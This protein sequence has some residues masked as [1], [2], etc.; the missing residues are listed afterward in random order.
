MIDPAAA[1]RLSSGRDGFV[2]VAVLWI[3]AALATLVSIYGLYVIN[4]AAAVSA[5]SDSIVADPLVTAGVEL[6]AYQLLGAQTNTRP[7]TGEFTT[8]VGAARLVIAFQTE[9]ARIDIN[10]A[11]KELLRGLFVS[12]GA[13][14]FDA[15]G[16]ANRIIAW[17]TNVAARNDGVI[18][19]DS[20]DSL[21][22]SG[23]LSYTPRHAPFV[24][25]S[26]LWLVY[27]IPRAF[28]ERILPYVTVYSGQAQV[29][30]KDAAPQVVAALPGMSPD[31]LQSTLAARQPGALD[32][33][34]QALGSFGSGAAL[35][36]TGP[37]VAAA[38]ISRVYRIG[39]QVEFNN[40]RRSAAEAVILLP[41]DGP[42]PYRVL[43]WR[44]ALDGTADQTL[45]FGRR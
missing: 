17:R 18:D 42:V 28:I 38:S 8:H 44:N 22:T 11:S 45:D 43:S 15:D 33:Q 14:P 27:G 35:D 40:G 4:S 9:A 16:Y 3:L 13:A 6:A 20:E 12:L 5:S 31:A 30:V 26:E 41:N 34:Q 1:N 29:D 19:A 2:V 23:G 39:V 21:Y 25:V 7:T 10:Q 24:H 37:R 36:S 32:Q